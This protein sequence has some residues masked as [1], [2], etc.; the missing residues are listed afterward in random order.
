MTTDILYHYTTA[1]ALIE[2]LKSN[3]VWA[4]DLR[5][6][7]DF[8]ELKYAENLIDI[9][10]DKATGEDPDLAGL[11]G[12]QP[13]S[14]M[15]LFAAYAL[16]LCEEGDQLSQWRGLMHKKG[17]AMLWDSTV[18]S[19]IRMETKDPFWA[20]CSINKRNKSARYGRPSK[21]I[22]VNLEHI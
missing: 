3:A 13:D 9:E 12:D 6:M 11:L 19:F 5:Y 16:C 20:R 4:S 22:S 18:I 17:P 15:D 7:N 2:I 14:F 21:N 10:L 1:Q 8:T